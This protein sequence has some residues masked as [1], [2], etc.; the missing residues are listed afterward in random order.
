M[1]APVVRWQ[2]VT[3]H[4]DDL[5]EFYA[6]VFGWRTTRDNPLGVREVHPTTA[7]A[8]PGSVWPAPPGAP[9][10]VQLFLEVPDVAVAVA[11]VERRGGAAIVPRSVLPMGEVMAIVRDPFGLSL[12]LVEATTTPSV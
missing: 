1:S 12:G 10:F 3:P 6:E 7:A 4:P 9:T 2:I 5:C 11:E 8:F